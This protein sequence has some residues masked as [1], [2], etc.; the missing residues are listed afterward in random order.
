LRIAGFGYAALKR[1]RRRT[2]PRLEL[3]M[4][5]SLR[6]LAACTVATALTAATCLV[7]PSRA[8]AQAG[9]SAYHLFQTPEQ[10]ARTGRVPHRETG[11]VEYFGGSV[12]S[13]VKVVSVIWGPNVKSQT[14]ADIGPFLAALVNSTFVDQLS[15]YDT[16]LTAVNGRA[17]T[18]QTIARGT[19]FGQVQITPKNQ[20]LTLSDKAIRKE[21]AY[22]I[23]AGKLPANDLNTLYMMYFP[24]DITIKLGKAVSCKAF[25][26]YHEAVSKTVTPSNTF[27]A[28]MPD[29][30]AGF[31]Y[32]TFA[33]SHEFAEAVT[34]NIP[35]PG[36]HPK[37]PQA[38]NT[39][40][41]Y[42]IADLCENNAPG[43]LTAGSN[44]YE[45]T[46]VYLNTTGA[47]STGSY[48]SP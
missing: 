22:Q 14:V 34:D 4:I 5:A 13:N 38:W 15:I 41:G 46:Q 30:N 42:E 10:M 25:G 39:A 11:E 31:S 16:D 21:L 3:D 7:S 40:D 33:S 47:C 37:Y 20:A 6:T 28:V 26:A 35:T 43:I 48:T 9:P 36:S 8:A 23:G 45:V 29:C 44:S 2:T 17:G 19:Y 18:D 27:Y 24:Q 12:F 32:L 1:P